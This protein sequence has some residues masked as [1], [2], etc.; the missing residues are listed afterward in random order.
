MQDDRKPGNWWGPVAIISAG[1]LVAI[2]IGWIF[3]LLAELV[4]TLGR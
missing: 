3:Y 1:I 2:A 4:K